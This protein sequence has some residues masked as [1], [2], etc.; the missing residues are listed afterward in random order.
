MP[1]S[2]GERMH[3][4]FY[5]REELQKGKHG[6][7]F[8]DR[9]RDRSVRRLNPGT[10]DS[11]SHCLDVSSSALDTIRAFECQFSRRISP[12]SSPTR[13][14]DRRRLGTADRFGTVVRTAGGRKAR[15]ICTR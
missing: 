15:G 11:F 2:E 6:L 12:L 4:Y 14:S 7:K 5:S 10:T 1:E 13:R 8:I 9:G 3:D